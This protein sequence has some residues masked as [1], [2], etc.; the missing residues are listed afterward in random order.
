MRREHFGNAKEQYLRQYIRT[1]D[2][3][4]LS[5]EELETVRSAALAI[6]SI[7]HTLV[8]PAGYAVIRSAVKFADKHGSVKITQTL[9]EAVCQT[10]AEERDLQHQA[11]GDHGRRP[12]RGIR[13][14]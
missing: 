8:T 6:E 4:R 5:L 3:R 13:R 12:S 10:E 9:V 1:A 2:G 14:A 11:A 7:T